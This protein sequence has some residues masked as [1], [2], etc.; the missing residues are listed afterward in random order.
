MV[1]RVV[2]PAL[3][4]LVFAGA[5]ITLGLAGWRPDGAKADTHWTYTY[6]DLPGLYV[7]DE[8]CH[9]QMRLVVAAGL[10]GEVPR[11]ACYRDNQ[12]SIEYLVRLSGGAVLARYT[13]NGYWRLVRIP[14]GETP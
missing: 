5:T 6:V 9:G 14:P 3:I 4:G 1:W 2:V 10:S 8:H 13:G 12:A 11:D 7:Y